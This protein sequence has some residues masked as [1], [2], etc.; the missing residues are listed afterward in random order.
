MCSRGASG[1]PCRGRATGTPPGGPSTRG[2]H[3]PARTAWRGAH[4]SSRSRR[5]LSGNRRWPSASSGRGARGRTELRSEA[6]PG[7]WDGSRG[8]RPWPAA[9]SERA[10]PR[11]GGAGAFRRARRARR[12]SAPGTRRAR[13]HGLVFQ[14]E[15]TTARRPARSTRAISREERGL[16]LRGNVVEGVEAHDRVEGPGGEGQR[17]HVGLHEE[18]VRSDAAPSGMKPAQ[19]KVDAD[20]SPDSLRRIARSLRTGWRP[21]R[22]RG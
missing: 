11:I 18:A 19:G 17:R 2:R 13:S 21:R 4:G 15:T 12:R 20:P 16:L 10:G 6:R 8:S 14:A 22:R 3:P 1:S 5:G 9:P 7:V